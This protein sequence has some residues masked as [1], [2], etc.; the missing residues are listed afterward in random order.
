MNVKKKLDRSHY[1]RSCSHHVVN[2]GRL[3]LCSDSPT[4]SPSET[5]S[6]RGAGPGTDEFL[7]CNYL[8]RVTY[9][10]QEVGLGLL[11]S[12][13]A[14]WVWIRI[15]LLFMGFLCLFRLNQRR[16]SLPV[17][18]LE[19]P[20]RPH[21]VRAS[22]PD[23]S[24]SLRLFPSSFHKPAAEPAEKGMKET[25]EWW[26]CSGWAKAE[27][28]ECDSFVQQLDKLTRGQ[29]EQRGR[30]A[31]APSPSKYLM[32]LPLNSF[33][34]PGARDLSALWELFDSFFF[35]YFNLAEQ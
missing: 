25:K 28:G 5:R 4:P 12:D 13:T 8:S 22:D 21:L 24:G 1:E 11:R 27:R 14:E 15:C 18:W 17:W 35:Y 34:A 30:G 16:V 32:N 20:A 10:F 3:S 23:Q 29:A 2:V 9:L 19:V 31:S 26:I 7:L 33:S 6:R